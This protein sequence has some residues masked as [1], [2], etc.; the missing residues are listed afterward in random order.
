[1]DNIVNKDD[2]QLRMEG[3]STGREEGP[4]ERAT[5]RCQSP[6]RL[7]SPHRGQME[8]VPRCLDDLVPP[9][10]AVRPMARWWSIWTCRPLSIQA[11]DGVAG[12]DASDPKLLVAQWL[13]ACVRGIG[14]ARE[15]EA[16]PQDSEAVRA[17]KQRMGSAEGK[18]IYRQRAATSETVN[19][20]LRRWR[21]LSRI[22][23]RRLAKALCVALWSAL[24]YNITHF[25]PL[26]GGNVGA[27]IRSGPRKGPKP[28]EIQFVRGTWK[29][30]KIPP[31]ALANGL[32]MN[33]T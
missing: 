8:L 29:T 1:M 25:A 15:L 28:R 27:E 33:I 21:G 18:Q 19:A 4:G 32:E 10:Q 2:A 12:R 24:A 7:R 31:T 30:P 11:R 5:A 20:E 23:V 14:S 3:L 17:W 6:V 26:P 16:K 22:T 9:Q 13:Y